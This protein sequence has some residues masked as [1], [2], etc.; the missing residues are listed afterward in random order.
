[1]KNLSRRTTKL[2]SGGRAESLETPR[3][4]HR[5]RR[6][7]QRIV[8]RDRTTLPK[9]SAC[10]YRDEQDCDASIGDK[11]IAPIQHRGRVTK[12]TQKKQSTMLIARTTQ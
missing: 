9:H 2:S 5:G 3:N 1:L 10:A 7:L 4:Q 8:R 12:P 6:L 11:I